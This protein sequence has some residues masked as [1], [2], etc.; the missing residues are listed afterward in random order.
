M[1]KEKEGFSLK[2]KELKIILEWG[3]FCHL[4][5]SIEL[6]EEERKLYKKIKEGIERENNAF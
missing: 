3:D 4:R 6:N 2:P 5:S 1:N